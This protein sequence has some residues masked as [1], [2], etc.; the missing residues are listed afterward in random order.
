MLNKDISLKKKPKRIFT[1]SKQ[2]WLLFASLLENGYSVETSLD[3]MQI[4]TNN[5]TNQLNQGIHIDKLILQGQK[6]KFYN[7]LSFFIQF[8]ALP[9]AIYSAYEMELFEVQTKQQLSKKCAYPLLVLSIAMISIF[10]FSTFLIPQLTANFSIGKDLIYIQV[11]AYCSKICIFILYLI[12][13]IVFMIMCIFLFPKFHAFMYH[14]ILRHF[15]VFKIYISY[16]LSG[17]MQALNEHGLSSLQTFTYLNKMHQNQFMYYVVDEINSDLYRGK[18]LNEIILQSNCLDKQFK[19]F[20]SIGYQNGN[21]NKSLNAYKSNAEI[22][23]NKILSIVSFSIQIISYTMVGI[24]LV[25]VYQIMLIPLN[26]L[27]Q[28]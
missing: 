9:K 6:G 1:F 2:Q 10:L 18:K 16:F 20:F 13:F 3:I 8:M 24:L 5:I 15:N 17:Y 4:H 12:L 14:Y 21:L 19:M 28:L 27:E 23:W 7:Y 11:V 25:C 26:I 22:K